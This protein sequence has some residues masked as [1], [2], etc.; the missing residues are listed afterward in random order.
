[1]L[2]RLRSPLFGIAARSTHRHHDAGG[3]GSGRERHQ[4]E[5]VKF[6]HNHYDDVKTAAA[7][8]IVNILAENFSST[9]N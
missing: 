4:P 2:V 9:Q 5:L 3:L 8:C 7:D 1:M 6:V